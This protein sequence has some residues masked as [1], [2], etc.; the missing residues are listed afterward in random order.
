MIIMPDDHQPKPIER[1]L[2]WMVAYR[3]FKYSEEQVRNES[4]NPNQSEKNHA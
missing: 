2:D 3:L 1:L 4:P